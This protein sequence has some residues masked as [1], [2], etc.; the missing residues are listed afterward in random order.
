[1]RLTLIS[2]IGFFQEIPTSQLDLFEGQARPSTAAV[3]KSL[4]GWNLESRNY[5]EAPAEGIFL[6]Q[7]DGSKLDDFD[8]DP[9][10]LGASL[11]AQIPHSIQVREDGIFLHEDVPSCDKC[12]SACEVPKVTPYVPQLFEPDFALVRHEL[13]LPVQDELRLCQAVANLQG[14]LTGGDRCRR[15]ETRSWHVG[16]WSKYR[17]VPR[18]TSVIFHQSKEAKIALNEFAGLVTELAVKPITALI[19]ELDPGYYKLASRYHP[20]SVLFNGHR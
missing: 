6:L 5:T 15:G 12:D 19:K 18:M 8:H 14:V 4:E 2:T 9:D 13:N 11:A 10:D 7:R 3:A 16:A 17:H 20:L 1:M